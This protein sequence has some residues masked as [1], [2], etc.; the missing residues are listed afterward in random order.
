MRK[1]TRKLLSIVVTISIAAIVLVSA[2]QFLGIVNIL[3]VSDYHTGIAPS[4]INNCNTQ[5]YWQDCWQGQSIP[6]TGYPK[7]EMMPDTK[8]ITSFSGA[9]GDDALSERISIVG[10]LYENSPIEISHPNRAYYNV[11]I[12]TD[13]QNPNW[14]QIV[15]LNYYDSTKII[16]NGGT[17]WQTTN[18]NPVGGD[19][20]EIKLLPIEIR[21]KGSIV[22]ALKVEARYEF[23]SSI[24]FQPTWQK[25]MSIDYAYLAS[26]NGA[27]NIE[28]YNHEDVPMYEIGE[29]VPIQVSADYSGATAGD[30]GRWQLWAFPLRGGSGRLLKE[31]T[32]DYFRETYQWILP[33][34]AWVR[35]SSNSQWTIELH[36][37]LFSTDFVDINTIDIKANAPP[38]PTMITS[39]LIP[40][41]GDTI[42]I[43][44]SAATNPNTNEQIQKFI[45]RAIYTDNGYQ[46]VY[47]DVAITPGHQDPFIAHTT[48]VPPRAGQFR[49]QVWAHDVAGRESVVPADIIIEMHEGKYRL[50]IRVLD[51]S[52]SFPIAGALVVQSGGT[53]KT[54]GTDGTVWFDLDQGS[55][56]FEITKLGYRAKTES[57]TI[58]STDRDVQSFM[59]RTENT[60]DLDV[61]VKDD[62]GSTVWGASV[63]VGG[64]E[65]L[66]DQTGVAN[67][68]DVAEGDYNIIAQKGTK[69]GKQS[70]TLDKS[71]AITITIREGGAEENGTVL[72]I[73]NIIFIIGGIVGAIVILYAVMYYMKRRRITKR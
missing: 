40:E 67:F 59:T 47:K 49:L 62:N 3:E 41:L 48:I 5:K 63:K 22:G 71:T 42:S 52:N 4:T 21:L 53:S 60:W 25:T 39:P 56:A 20:Q 43:D 34:D 28:G 16:V 24:P 38:T 46:F 17:G 73:S 68:K 15:G 70:I 69:S 31:W 55:Y 33:S 50:T 2:L 26:G 64:T 65:K 57:W 27:L 72:G 6:G 10:N 45:L 51:Q 12:R 19:A 7:Q 14:Q 54:T 30:T 32:Y 13:P 1:N 36:N 66:T 23:G 61:T 35:G 37:T 29:T 9:D 8:Y 58:S 18:Y 11:Y 44:I